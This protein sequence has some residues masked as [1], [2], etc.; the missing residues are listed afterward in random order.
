MTKKGHQK[1]LRVG[2]HFSGGDRNFVPERAAFD[3]IAPGG[4]FARYAT[5]CYSDRLWSFAATN[6]L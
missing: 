1:C 4:T 6:H 5:A 2:W 3:V